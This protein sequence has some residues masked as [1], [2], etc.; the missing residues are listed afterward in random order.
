[1]GD[2]EDRR[3]N[4]FLN[5]VPP[6]EH[7]VPSGE[8]A[9]MRWDINSDSPIMLRAEVF[10]Y[11]TDR[12]HRRDILLAA[13]SKYALL[14][15]RVPGN[16]YREEDTRSSVQEFFSFAKSALTIPAAVFIFSPAQGKN[17]PNPDPHNRDRTEQVKQFLGEEMETE[18]ANHVKDPRGG[19]AILFERAETR[20]YHMTVPNKD[21]EMVFE[22]RRDSNP[23]G[24]WPEIRYHYGGEGVIVGTT[25][26]RWVPPTVP[27]RR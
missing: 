25:D 4:F 6:G 20:E 19:T 9:C 17:F 16:I 13:I 2:N 27:T 12:P 24:D 14:L 8:L 5:F 11:D 18:K 26:P 23:R 15:G 22:I 7:L 1:M 21:H 10:P 3:V